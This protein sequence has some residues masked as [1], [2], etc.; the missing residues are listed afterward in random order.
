M[1]SPQDSD[2]AHRLIA[3]AKVAG[4]PV[5]NDTGERLG[6]VEDVMIDKESG[7]IAY[8]VLSF[9]G[10]LGMGERHHP[11][12]WPALRYD[13]ALA[14]YVVAL[15]PS[16]LEGAPAL[17]DQSGAAWEDPVWGARI[18]DYYGVSPYWSVMP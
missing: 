9:G 12:P 18:H 13:T 15:D 4:T 3:G 14:G 7:R 16:T 11:L 2:P 5:Y 8:A 6:T 17:A 1:A 10:F